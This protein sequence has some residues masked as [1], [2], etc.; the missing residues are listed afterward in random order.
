MD[1]ESDSYVSR[2]R[3]E[4]LEE[5]KEEERQM[6]D[7]ETGEEDMEP[8]DARAE[9]G[10][11]VKGLLESESEE[12]RTFKTG[13]SDRSEESSESSSDDE[14][15]REVMEYGETSGRNDS[16]RNV[17]SNFPLAAHSCGDT[18]RA[19]QG[20]ERERKPGRAGRR[21]P[22]VVRVYYR[23]PYR[24][25]RRYLQEQTEEDKNI[26]R[27]QEKENPEA[28]WQSGRQIMKDLCKSILLDRPDSD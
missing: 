9:T 26:L 25:H 11:K 22:P 2:R 18:E 8:G 16:N 4:V 20:R 12:E 14:L 17:T 24:E 28:V 13:S 19:R 6:T 15:S 5:E 10:A 23:Q 27:Q 3:E 21:P 1:S 7:P